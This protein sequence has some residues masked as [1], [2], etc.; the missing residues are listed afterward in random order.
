MTNALAAAIPAAG[1]LDSPALAM[2]LA[3][4][5]GMVCQAV[6]RH[7]QLPG[8]VLLLLAG[9]L[10]GPEVANFIRPSALGSALPMIVGMSVAII[11]FEGG[12]NLSLTGLRREAVVIRR[13]VTVGALITALGG[14]G[15]A[16]LFLG[17]DWR[18]AAPFGALVVVTGP[19]VITPLMRRIDVRRNISTIL[20]GEGVFI[21][22]LGAIAA[23]VTLEVVL[24]TT[25]AG[26][27]TDLLGVVYRL[28][29]GG[30]VGMLGGLC[31]GWLLKHRWAVPEGLENVFTLS[32]VLVLFELSES[33]ME[34]TGILA[35]VLAGIVVGNMD[36]RVQ[37]ELKEF[38]EQLTVL[39]IGLLFVLLAAT[40]RVEDVVGLGW[41]GVATV[42]LLMILIRPLNVAASTWGSNLDGRERLFLAWVAPRGIVAAAVS[43][44]FARRL[45]AEGIP[46]GPELQALVFLVIAVTV[47]IQGGLAGWVASLLGIR[48]E[49]DRGYAVVGANPIGRVLARTL[50]AAGQPTVLID[51]SAPESQE[52]EEEGLDVVF[53]NAAEERTLLRAE[54]DTRKGL[55]AVT[56]N[57]AVNTLVATR[58]SDR[59]H[60]SHLSVAL[61]RRQREVETAQVHEIGADVLFGEPVDLE[62]WNHELIHGSVDVAAW[63][64][65]GESSV[66][67]PAGS[68]GSGKLS[69]RSVRLLPLVHVRGD[70]V[71]PVTDRCLFQ[72]GDRVYYAWTY[73]EGEAA[74]DWLVSRGWRPAVEE[75]V[76]EEPSEEE[77]DAE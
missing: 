22:A 35:A 43:S 46:G 4:V 20:E 65:R 56:R 29:I 71:V 16:L 50:M 39:L 27:A 70:R 77:P 28:G 8:I 74:G 19:T 49:T 26:R 55:V 24:E 52:A 13:L 61:N 36:T 33:M 11:L 23:I 41:G 48:R 34:E 6:A 58:A 5:V 17:W 76:E 63:E 14:A 73:R 30:G 25:A 15:A 59:F 31:M 38:K 12:L 54:L 66:D 40:V 64:Y 45:E 57:Q 10:L 69:G 47:V 68:G 44:L 32:V 18:L 67:S 60:L 72:P 37:E 2:A 62:Y 7:L 1:F 75:P 51:S 3:L 42:A 21:D 53:G 9:V